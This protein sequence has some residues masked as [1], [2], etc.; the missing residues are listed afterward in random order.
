MCALSSL[1]LGWDVSDAGLGDGDHHWL[2]EGWQLSNITA[3]IR[4][5]SWQEMPKTLHKM[6]AKV[7]VLFQR[8]S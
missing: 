2:W 3:T 1:K 7:R 4:A 6:M 8:S 5:G